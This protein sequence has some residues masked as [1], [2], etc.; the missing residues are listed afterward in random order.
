MRKA[1]SFIASLLLSL[2]TMAVP[3]RPTL[4]TVWTS[5]STALTVILQG[6]E[7]CHFLVTIDGTPVVE[8][9]NGFYRL[10]PELKD[11]I[12]ALW[13]ERLAQRNIPRLQKA[14]AYQAKDRQAISQP[15]IYTDKKKGLVILVNFSDKWMQSA[16]TQEVWYQQFNQNGYSRNGCIGSVSDYF[17]DQSYGMFNIEFDVVG[18]VTLNNVY[19]YYGRNDDKGN[20]MHPCEMVIEACRKADKRGV[21]FADYDWD[22]DGEVDIV[23]IVYAGYGESSGASSNTVWPH[24]W[25]LAS[26]QAAGDG[27]GPLTLDKVKINTYAASCELCGFRGTTMDG[28][29]TAC[30]EFSHCLGLPDMYDTSTSSSINSMGRWD[31]MGAGNYCGPQQQGEV[32]AGF[33]AYERNFAGW[34]DYTEL[35]TAC[36]VYDMPTLEDAPVA[37][38]IYNDN[39]HDE[40]FLLE[41]RQSKKWDQYVGGHGLLVYHVDYNEEAWKTNKVNA[42]SNHQR[43]RYIPAGRNFSIS[44]T[45]SQ[46]FP[47]TNNVTELTNT[48]HSTVGAQLFNMNTD[49]SYNMS[50]PITEISE[51]NERISFKFMGGVA[52]GIDAI[53]SDTDHKTEYYTIDGILVSAPSKPGLYIKRTDEHSQKVYI[54]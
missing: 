10:A 27:T 23:F 26:G 9:D 19:S 8:E 4:F 24:E 45:S 41:N 48:S 12:A 53:S 20:D 17:Y 36:N 38:I 40:Y 54:R 31:I 3:A 18:P 35:H 1:I 6:D 15:Y 7:T 43:M 28:I 30:H 46:T 34:L 32:P 52:D 16:H 25:T 37:Y 29:G 5:D 42:S 11:D 49:G 47:G 44:S 39:C 50:K 21:N 33:T 22:E 51:Q 2:H 14:K 13:S